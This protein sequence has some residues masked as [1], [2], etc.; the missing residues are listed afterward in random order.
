MLYN[1]H[2]HTSRCHHADGTDREYVE[3]A[4]KA[5]VK[6]L[7]FSD[8]APYPSLNIIPKKPYRVDCC[9]EYVKSVLAL[10]KEYQKEIDI[11]LGFELEY[12][13]ELH[14]QEVEYLKTF[15]Y[16]YLILGQHQLI[17]GKE[18]KIVYTNKPTYTLTEYVDTVI[19]GL[20]TGDF[21]MLAHPDVA[22]CYAPKEEKQKEYTRLCKCAKELNIPLEINLL[23]IRE[24]RT[25]PSEDF[26]DIAKD[27]ENDIIIGVDAHS[28]SAFLDKYALMKAMEIVQKFNLKLITQPF[29]K[30]MN[31]RL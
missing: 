6:V 5:G 24:G 3:S 18:Y 2:T 10:K 8:H 22:N 4:I 1:Y 21:K 17:K 15:G 20:K 7:G 12:Y 29:I 26:F 13:P 19:Q 30:Q 31:K 27:V 23:G 28:P 14:S 9:E 25:Y 11:L 16:D